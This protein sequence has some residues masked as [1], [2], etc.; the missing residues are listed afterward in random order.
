MTVQVA[1]PADL[2]RHGTRVALAPC[3]LAQVGRCDRYNLLHFEKLNNE[4]KLKIMKIIIINFLIN[5]ICQQIN[6]NVQIQ[7]NT[8]L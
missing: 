2:L 5:F 4:E 7:L 1:A 3:M 6:L 8:K